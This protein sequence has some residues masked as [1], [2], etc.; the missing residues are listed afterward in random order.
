MKI[1]FEY[2]EEIK[3]IKFSILTVNELNKN[4][5]YYHV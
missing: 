1:I 4:D 3:N 2:F 5:I